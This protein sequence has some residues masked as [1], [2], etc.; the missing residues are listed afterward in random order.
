MMLIGS[1]LV[2]SGSRMWCRIH[3]GCAKLCSVDVDVAGEIMEVLEVGDVGVGA[4]DPR[5]VEGETELVDIARSR[6]NLV[7][8]WN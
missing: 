4:D 5:V 7:S 6:Q 8:Y 3:G 2:V 1:S